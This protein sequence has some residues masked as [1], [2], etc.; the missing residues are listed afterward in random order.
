MNFPVL[1][2]ISPGSYVDNATKCS[3]GVV[4]AIDQDQLDLLL[5]T[6]S[7]TRA[8]AI[9]KAG[10]KAKRPLKKPLKALQRKKKPCKTLPQPKTCKSASLPD[11]APGID[12]NA[13]PTRAEL[14][15]QATKLGIK[16]DGRWSDKRLVAVISEK[17]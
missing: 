4:S 13:A 16:Y 3:Y 10:D 11:N 7:L 12:D 6:H 1:L 15:Q 5:E 9:A 17:V 14:E 2:Y 8:E